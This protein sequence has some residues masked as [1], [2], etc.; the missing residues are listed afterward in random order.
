MHNHRVRDIHQSNTLS[1][2]FI[3]WSN[4]FVI[5]FSFQSTLLSSY[6]ILFKEKTLLIVCVIKNLVVLFKKCMQLIV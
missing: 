4:L 6:M 5:L 2:T 1:K 3:S